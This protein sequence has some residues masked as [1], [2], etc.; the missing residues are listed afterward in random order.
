MLGK[1][2]GFLVDLGG[3]IL[4][5]LVGVLG[6]GEG[7]L[8]GVDKSFL[9]LLVFFD[10]R[11]GFSIEAFDDR[12]K[13][14]KED[15]AVEADEVLELYL[16]ATELFGAILTAE[17]FVRAFGEAF[18]VAFIGDLPAHEDDECEAEERICIDRRDEQKRREEH[19]KIPIVDAAGGAAAVFHEPRLEGAEKE[20]AD[21]VTDAVGEGNY[22]EEVFID[23]ME[24]IEREDG[25]IECDP[26]SRDGEGCFPRL[27]FRL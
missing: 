13:L 24:N 25:G 27:I 17:R 2:A 14:F 12:L 10:Y 7:E 26:Y 22:C 11:F 18:G 19:C 5:A 21:D 16:M 3:S 1:V 23:D 6:G 4:G 9:D 8:G 15:I 20:D